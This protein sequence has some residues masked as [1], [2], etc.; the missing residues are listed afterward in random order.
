MGIPK[1]TS[2]SEVGE[3]TIYIQNLKL[4]KNF[5]LLLRIRLGLLLFGGIWEHVVRSRI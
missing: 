5:K 1:E 4:L 2:I 3:E